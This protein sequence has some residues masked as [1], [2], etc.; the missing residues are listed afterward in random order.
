MMKIIF[1]RI[2]SNISELEY[3]CPLYYIEQD[4]CEEYCSQACNSDAAKLSFA[5]KLPTAYRVLRVQMVSAGFWN[6][7]P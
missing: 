7:A 1:C 2:P 4:P 5:L 3:L 6:F